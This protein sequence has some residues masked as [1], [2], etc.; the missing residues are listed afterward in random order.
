[1]NKLDF[2][3]KKKYLVLFIATNGLIRKE[4]W[5]PVV[6]GYA[7]E[8]GITSVQIGDLMNIKANQ[9]VHIAVPQNSVRLRYPLNC[10]SIIG[11][12]FTNKPIDGVPLDAENATEFEEH[13]LISMFTLDEAEG[14]VTYE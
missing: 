7:K 9:V 13:G 4:D 14:V 10:Q 6:K 12:G 11:I 5:T 2:K 8:H 1:M 3:T